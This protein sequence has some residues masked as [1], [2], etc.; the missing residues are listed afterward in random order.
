MAGGN[1]LALYNVAGLKIPRYR[2]A[3]ICLGIYVGIYAGFSI[4][5]KFAPPKP[6]T[7]ESKEQEEYVKKYLEH[8]EQEAHK[9]KLLREKYTGSSGL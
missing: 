5:G 8:H 4:K 1:P 7:Y 3:I 9:P 6:L 2:M